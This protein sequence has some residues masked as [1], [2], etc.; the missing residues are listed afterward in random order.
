M[1]LI[2]ILENVIDRETFLEFIKA[3]IEDREKADTEIIRKKK[4]NT[5]D[6][7]WDRSGEWENGEIAGYLKAASSWAEAR[8][9]QRMPGN[10]T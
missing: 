2:E 4:L 7:I 1:S 5:Y 10:P 9:E 8:K 3:L 6:P